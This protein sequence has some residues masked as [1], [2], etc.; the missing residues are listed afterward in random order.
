MDYL[1]RR[2][3]H[4]MILREFRRL[5]HQSQATNEWVGI[6]ELK[7]IYI[8]EHTVSYDFVNTSYWETFTDALEYANRLMESWPHIYVDEN[9][10]TKDCR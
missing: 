7:G 1:H 9:G 8:V 2:E 4:P 3:L 5:K 6:E 10:D